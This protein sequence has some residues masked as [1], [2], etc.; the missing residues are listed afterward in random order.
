VRRVVLGGEDERR[1]IFA[2]LVGCAIDLGRGEIFKLVDVE[3][4]LDIAKL[5]AG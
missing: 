4:L 3:G 2:G 5:G 1:G